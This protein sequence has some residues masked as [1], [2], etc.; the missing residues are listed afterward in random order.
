MMTQVYYAIGDIHGEVFQLRDLLTSIKDFHSVTHADRSA[1]LIFLGDYVDRGLF[2]KDVID[3]IRQGVDG[4]KTVAIR[5]NHE[6]WFTECLKYDD[7][8]TWRNWVY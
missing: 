7:P 6:Y 8:K 3:T 4:F 2:S 5:G 1:T